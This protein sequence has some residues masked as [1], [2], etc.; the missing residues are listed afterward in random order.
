MKWYTHGNLPLFKKGNRYYK[1][2]NV[3]SSNLED[4]KKYINNTISE[5]SN[6]GT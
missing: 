3:A 1:V 6:K 5:K 2:R 4:I